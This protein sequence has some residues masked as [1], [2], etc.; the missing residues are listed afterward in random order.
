MA[1][2]NA[3]KELFL[4]FFKG[5]NPEKQ[6]RIIAILRSIED[7]SG[8][9]MSTIFKATDVPYSTGAVLLRVL[10]E[11]GCATSARGVGKT[12]KKAEIPSI[13]KKGIYLL[14]LTSEYLE[15]MEEKQPE[16][17]RS[18]ALVAHAIHPE[19][20][21]KP[22]IAAPIG[23]AST[24]PSNDEA[25]KCAHHWIIEAAGGPTSQGTCRLCGAQK[26][27]LNYIEAGSWGDTP[28]DPEIQRERRARAAQDPE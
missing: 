21:S 11:E 22:L 12:N 7:H 19:R 28:D 10:K 24:K 2:E 20:N 13:T 6:K 25:P 9:P 8:E 26:D 17:K 18:S 27:F 16:P 5:L 3:L 23:P 14:E 4:W 15:W 1:T